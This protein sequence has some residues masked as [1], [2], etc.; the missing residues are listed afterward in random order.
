MTVRPK[1]QQRLLHFYNT[2][3]FPTANSPFELAKMPCFK[4][5][6]MQENVCG[7]RILE[8]KSLYLC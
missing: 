2:H 1:Q 5:K 4:R 7:L 3:A 8:R 6:Q